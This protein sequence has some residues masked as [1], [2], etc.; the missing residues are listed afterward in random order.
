MLLPHL[1]SDR[2]RQTATPAL[3]YTMELFYVLSNISALTNVKWYLGIPFNDSS[4]WSL[5]IAEYGQQILG[6][7]LLGLQ[8]ANEPDLYARHKKR[9]DG[10]TQND[11]FGEFGD[12]IK[13]MEANPNI[14]RNNI[15]IG[16][17]IA[18]GD[19]TP[20][21]VWDTGFID[22]YANNLAAL[23]VEK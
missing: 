11:F 13:T 15:L 7:N 5:E 3:V 10:Y 19:W 21:M 16:P 17:N 4:N 14:P 23:S 9:P 20:Q 8:A 12:L 1:A 2:R 22:A 18:T 6:D